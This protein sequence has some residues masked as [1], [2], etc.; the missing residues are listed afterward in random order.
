[1]VRPLASS[2]REVSQLAQCGTSM[3]LPIITLGASLCVGNMPTGLS[4]LDQQGFILIEVAQRFYNQVKA[5]PVTG[6][7]TRSAIV[8]IQGFRFFG[9]SRVQV[10]TKH[11]QC[12]FL[13]PAFT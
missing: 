2:S 3:E 5:S 11:A 8:L 12:S 7:L 13:Y 9:Y 4:G 1:M 10:N 6:R